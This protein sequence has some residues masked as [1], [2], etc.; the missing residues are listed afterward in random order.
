[1]K[2]DI[3]R[4]GI[5]LLITICLL[6]SVDL[7]VGFVGDR[8]AWNMPNFSG[9]I[10]K[11]NYRLHRMDAEVVIIGSSRGAHH[12]VTS[13]LNDSID[14]L[15]GRHVTVYNAAIQGK[16]A[17]S[18]CCAAEVILSRYHPKLLIFDMPE[19]QMRSSDFP[20]DLEFS[21][22]YY[23][24]DTIVR[25]YLDNL[26][27][28][29]QIVM[30]SS[31]CRYNSKVIRVLSSYLQHIPED[32]GYAPM[33]GCAIDTSKHEPTMS[34]TG[35]L[36]LNPYSENNLVNVFKKCKASDVQLVMVCSPWFRENMGNTQL[37][38]LCNKYDI[39]FIDFGDTELFNSHPDWFHDAGHLNDLGA[40]AYTEIFFHEIKPMIKAIYYQ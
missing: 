9:Q 26:G 11:D 20:S 30:K 35:A 38:E 18:N 39:L 19:H 3:T 33:Y 27:A 14:N 40:H 34:D 16:F 8:L 13:Q 4:F 17:N 7:I 22:P 24:T 32:D 28:K 31:L 25:R 12:Y 36:S 5:S 10:A 23:W 2:K 1:M 29:E 15:V 21:S 6:A 37:E